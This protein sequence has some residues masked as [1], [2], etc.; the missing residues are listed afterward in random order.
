MLNRGFESVLPR[1]ED[2][3]VLMTTH[4]HRYRVHIAGGSV[5]LKTRHRLV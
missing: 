2:R 3:H 5:G 1:L 4:R